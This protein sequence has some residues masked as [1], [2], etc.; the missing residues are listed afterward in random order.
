MACATSKPNNRKP[1]TPTRKRS[2]NR[3][4]YWIGIVSI[5]VYVLSLI[6]AMA[7]PSL[8]VSRDASE[9][10]S[11][12]DRALTLPIRGMAINL[13]F[14]NDQVL[15]EQAVDEIAALGFN[16]LMISTP[17]FQRDG[18]AETI[19]VQVGKGRGPARKQLKALI[20][21]AHDKG[22]QVV[23]MPV[24][25]FTHPR[26]NEWRGKIYPK[27]WE[28]WWASYRAAMAYFTALAVETNVE[29]LCVGSELLTTERQTADWRNL[30]ARVRET[31]KGKLTYSA[32][33]NHYD[34]PGFWDRLDYVGVNAYF[35]L[36]K[37]KGDDAPQ[38][39]LDQ[40]WRAHRDRLLAYGKRIGKP[41]LLTEVGYPSLPWAVSEPWNYTHDGSE[42][43]DEAAQL[44]GYQA[45]LSAWG[46]LLLKDDD[47]PKE[48]VAG[49]IF[50][51]WDPYV[52][53][54]QQDT[55]YGLKGK[56]VYGLVREWLKAN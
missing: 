39:L 48:P 37:G 49:A 54:G 34:W 43:S 47:Q 23:L 12:W 15:Y 56:R 46:E 35:D 6:G 45:F 22:L 53:G 8:D 28:A 29:V 33:F 42:A 44:R 32:N 11:Q 26:G 3:S 19:R 17:V 41:V 10:I 38:L 24:V 27:N 55:G 20:N 30:I 50:Y 31:Y 18:A 7:T 4:F 5:L 16:T 36:T 1:A 25:L 51:E 21:L 9:S 2:L 40:S 52:L 14:N 13:H